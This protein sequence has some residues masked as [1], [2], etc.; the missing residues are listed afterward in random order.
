MNGATVSNAMRV[1]KALAD[2]GSVNPA[3]VAG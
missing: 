3:T 2:G 1:R